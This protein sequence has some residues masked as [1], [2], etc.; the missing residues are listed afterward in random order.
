MREKKFLGCNLSYKFKEFI[1]LLYRSDLSLDFER[2]R[3][4]FLS[5]RCL[6]QR[7]SLL[8]H[9]YSQTQGLE[10]CNEMHLQN[11]SLDYEHNL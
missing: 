5:N 8:L 9:K 11:L 2:I 6:S 3:S 1:N 4:H 7:S 10:F